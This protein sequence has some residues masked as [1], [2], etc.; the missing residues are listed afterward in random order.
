MINVIQN[1]MYGDSCSVNHVKLYILHSIVK[2]VQEMQ[3]PN[4]HNC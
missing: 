3:T 2:K 1:I 4:W